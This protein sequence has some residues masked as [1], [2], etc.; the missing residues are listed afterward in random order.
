MIFY[1]AQV[2]SGDTWVTQWEATTAD[3][4]ATVKKL[5]A[6]GYHSPHIDKIEIEPNRE[7]ILQALNHASV[8]R[9]NWDGEQIQ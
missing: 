8:H 9:I 6:A 3:A 1:R 2:S 7:S 5:T 4:R